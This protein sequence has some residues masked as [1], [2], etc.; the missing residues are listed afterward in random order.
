VSQLFFTLQNE[1]VRFSNNEA[2]VGL[3]GKGVTGD[4]VYIELPEVGKTVIKGEPCATIESVKSIIEV[5]APATGVISGINDNVYDDPD[6]ITKFPQE[7]WLFK[8]VYE[9]D[10]DIRGLLDERQYKEL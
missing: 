10:A 8:V 1:W 7:T 5:H 9:G 4:V 6:M 3:T 2:C